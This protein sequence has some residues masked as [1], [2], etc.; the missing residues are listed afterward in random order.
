MATPD[1]RSTPKILLVEDNPLHA[2]LVMTMLSEAWP[3]FDTLAQARRL[4]SALELAG[5]ASP[6]CILLDLVLPDADGV[7]AV[8]AMVAAEPDVPIVVLSS[9]DDDATAL[10]ALAE[11][12]QDYLVKGI[13]DAEGLA[14]AIRYAI[15][16]HATRSTPGR[17]RVVPFPTLPEPPGAADGPPPAGSALIDRRGTIRY[18]E[19]GVAEMLGRPLHEI[20]GSS[21]ATLTHPDDVPIWDDALAGTTAVIDGTRSIIVRVRHG[22]GHDQRVTVQLDGLRGGSGEIEAYLATYHPHMEEGTVASG[23]TYVVM[24]DWSG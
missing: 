13:V 17:R 11:G 3:G 19:E 24:S 22:A 10:R 7:E 8:E 21:I 9:H 5:T 12:A 20:V 15:G 23:G 6:D 16:R 4:D 2:R 14:R 1:D 18:L